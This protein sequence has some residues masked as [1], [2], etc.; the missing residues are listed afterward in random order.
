MMAQLERMA[1]EPPRRMQALPLLM[2]MAA[3]SLVT[4]GR[5]SKMMPTTPRGTR[6]CRMRRPLGRVHMRSAVPMGSGRAATSSRPRAMS[7]T[8]ASVRVSRSIKADF[9]PF[10]P[11]ARRSSAFACRIAPQCARSACAMARSAPSR[12]EEP[13]VAI[14][15]AALRACFPKSETMVMPNVASSTVWMGG[16]F[17]REGAQ[18][19]RVKTGDPPRAA[20]PPRQRPTNVQIAGAEDGG[21]TR[22]EKTPRDFKSRVSAI[23]PLRHSKNFTT[24]A[25]FRQGK[26]TTRLQK[27]ADWRGFSLFRMEILQK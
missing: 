7:S 24:R 12:T 27:P 17:R 11:A 4:L 20:N 22:T 10:S 6:F 2:Q 15:R 13:S 18:A 5:D 26:P 9:T 25:P 3:A 8:R 21:R 1:S 14:S 19:L 23:P 16:F